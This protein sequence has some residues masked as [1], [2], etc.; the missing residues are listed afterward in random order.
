VSGSSKAGR[1]VTLVQ[2]W[3]AIV[4]LAAAG[5]MALV[6]MAGVAGPHGKC[7]GETQ[8]SRPGNAICYAAYVDQDKTGVTGTPAG[9]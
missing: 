5:V 6:A 3:V 4:S 1:P 9:S 2:F 7:P 8:V